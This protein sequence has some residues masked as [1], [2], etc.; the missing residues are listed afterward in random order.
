MASSS[1]TAA[2]VLDQAM[3]NRLAV[4]QHPKE[5]PRVL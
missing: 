3:K 4:F 2:D 5:E 1:A